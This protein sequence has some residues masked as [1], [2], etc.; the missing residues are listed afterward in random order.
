MGQGSEVVR[1]SGGR[2]HAPTTLSALSYGI[3][4]R[5]SPAAN[6]MMLACTFG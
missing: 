5:M 6:V 1:I 4:G 2:F 3:C